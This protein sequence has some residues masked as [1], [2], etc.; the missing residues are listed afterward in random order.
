[1]E[2]ITTHVGNARLSRRRGKSILRQAIEDQSMVI[3]SEALEPRHDTERILASHKRKIEDIDSDAMKR[4]R[5]AERDRADIEKDIALTDKLLQSENRGLELLMKRKER[6]QKEQHP[7]EVV[8]GQIV[9]AERRALNLS[10][11]KSKLSQRLHRVQEDLA[12]EMQMKDR[13]RRETIDETQRRLR[14]TQ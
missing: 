8:E 14:E 4:K 1:V 10:E 6:M 7:T 5:E 2:L 11:S 9:E 12:E 3:L 13:E